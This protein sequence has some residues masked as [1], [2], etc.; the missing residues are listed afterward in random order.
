M[1]VPISIIPIRIKGDVDHGDDLVELIL[2]SLKKERQ[3]LHNNDIIVIAQKIVSKVEGRVVPLSNVKPSKPAYSIASKYGK[4]PR[5]VELILQESKDIVKMERGIIIV[6]TRHGFVCANAGVDQSN[7]K[8]GYVSLLPHNP[9]RS[10]DKI[11]GAIMKRTGKRVSVLITDTFGR[12]FREGQ[13][14]V[15]I[16][17]SGLEPIRDYRG[18]KDMFGRKLKVTEIAV[19]DEIAGAAELVMGKLNRTPVAII[20]G[21]RYNNEKGSARQLTRNRRKDLFR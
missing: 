1:S 2:S 15:A 14:N 13:V 10:A 17:I 8:G 9:D 6:E 18:V 4:D 7:V 19:A 20:R 12:P 3:K 21:F 5:V 16:G 11:R